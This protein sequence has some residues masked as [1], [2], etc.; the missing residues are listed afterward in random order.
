[1]D[2][3]T[4]QPARTQQKC[5][6]CVLGQYVYYSDRDLALPW[7]STCW[8]SKFTQSYLLYDGYHAICFM[9]S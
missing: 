1:V 9:V 4:A 5:T 2:P 7:F 6:P 3:I 8:P